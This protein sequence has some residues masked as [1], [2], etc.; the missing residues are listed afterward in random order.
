MN[1]DKNLLDSLLRHVR[2]GEAVE[3]LLAM[4]GGII[5]EDNC[6]LGVCVDTYTHVGDD[7]LFRRIIIATGATLD[8]TVIDAAARPHK[9]T[10]D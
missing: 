10:T 6:E 2:I 7:E 4:H 5:I 9:S 1:D 3:R 8:A